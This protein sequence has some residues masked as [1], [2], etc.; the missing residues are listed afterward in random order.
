VHAH[1]V[2]REGQRAEGQELTEFCRQHIAGYKIPRS[3]EFVESLPKTG[4]GK[5]QKSGLRDAHWQGYE[6]RV[7]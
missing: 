5:I 2:L 1:G 7:N 3:V 6:R 4:S